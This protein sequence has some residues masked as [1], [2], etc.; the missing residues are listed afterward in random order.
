MTIHYNIERLTEVIKKFYSLTGISISIVNTDYNQ[1]V[2]VPTDGNAF[3]RLVQGTEEGQS[4]CKASDCALFDKCRESAASVTHKCH[5]GLCDTAVPIYSDF[6][7]LGFVVFGQVM[8]EGKTTSFEE[9]YSSVRDL[10]LDKETVRETYGGLRLI[11]NEKIESAAEI[12][13]I[14]A[15]YI[16]LEHLIEPR[17]DREMEKIAGYIEEHLAEKV[18]VKDICAKFY[19]SQNTLYL[20]FR[21]Q[22]GCTVGEYADKAR[23]KQACRLL[24]TTSMPIHD[25]CAKVGI[26]NYHYFI[27]HFKQKMGESPLRY[28]KRCEEKKN[29]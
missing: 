24:S 13:T 4:R 23:M 22:Y 6:T 12:V 2:R 21:S 8:S 7:L 20:R 10:G 19:I 18:T 15:K 16:W 17:Y 5:S 25:V 14:L 26:N 9:V 3:C 11:E 29:K 1:I 27:R 28:R